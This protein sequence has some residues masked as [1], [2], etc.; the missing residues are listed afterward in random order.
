MPSRSRLRTVKWDASLPCI[1]IGHVRSGSTFLA[2]CL[3]THP[4]I[5]CFRS[6][7]L[8]PGS[9]WFK[10]L[11]ARGPAVLDVALSQ[12]GYKASV[13]KLTLKH[14]TP[15]V[16]RHL[17]KK[18]KLRVI[19]LSRDNV[20]RTAVSAIIHT[21]FRRGVLEGNYGHNYEESPPASIIIDPTVL[22]TQCRR[23]GILQ[24]RLRARVRSLKKPTL[25]LTYADLV[26]QDGAGVD[27]EF[28]ADDAS[29]RLC[30]FLRVDVRPMFSTIRR[31]NRH[32]LSAIIENW[33][34][35]RKAVS[36]SVF[37]EYL[38]EG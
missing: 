35:V 26:G 19:Q 2:H 16:R 1:I 13:C 37:A 10:K 27:V 24:N 12:W 5:H 25:K 20:L 28:L 7:P 36:G 8:E 38:V 18:P 4:E 15:R 14:L 31:V 21:R 30:K 6:E 29:Q 33:L 22:L 34:E 23:V 11:S 32:K 9:I 3:S 17:K